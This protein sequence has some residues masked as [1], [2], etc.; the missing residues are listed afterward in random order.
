MEGFERADRHARHLPAVAGLLATIAQG[1]N[2]S[3]MRFCHAC[4]AENYDSAAHCVE[5]GAKLHVVGKTFSQEFQEK[6]LVASRSVYGGVSGSLAA[7]LYG[8][9]CAVLVPAIF[10]HKLIFFAGLVIVFAVACLCGRMLANALNDTS[11]K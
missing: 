4:L 8:L 5:C 7:G 10:S 11:L 6:T 2:A 3:N 9:A 1:G